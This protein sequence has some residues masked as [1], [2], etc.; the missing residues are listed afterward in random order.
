MEKNKFVIVK[1]NFYLDGKE[2]ISKFSSPFPSFMVS[3]KTLRMSVSL[4]INQAS[5]GPDHYVIIVEKESTEVKGRM[6]YTLRCTHC[7]TI[8]TATAETVDAE[9]FVE[10]KIKSLEKEIAE[11]LKEIE[12]ELEDDERVAVPLKDFNLN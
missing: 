6:E 12:K 2:I 7:G 5:E 8:I 3:D 9:K 4:I 11:H 1:V 10:D